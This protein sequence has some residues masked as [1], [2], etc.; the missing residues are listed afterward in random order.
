MDLSKIPRLS[1]DRENPVADQNPPSQPVAPAD[2][3]PF[4]SRATAEG[5]LAD[6]WMS[7][8]VGVIFL[9]LGAGFAKW[10]A[11]TALGRTYDSHVAWTSGAK[12]GQTVPYWELSG[13]QALTESSVFLFG[14]ACIIEA[15]ALAATRFRPQAARLSIILSVAMALVATLYSAVVAVLVFNDGTMPIISVLIVAFGGYMVLQ[16]WRLLRCSQ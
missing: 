4:A 6:I 9:M 1:G 8:V 12:A 2:P 5:S 16:Q 15:A 13:Y 7:V 3:I 14:L 10:V 11:A